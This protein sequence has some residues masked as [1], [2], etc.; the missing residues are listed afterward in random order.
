MKGCFILPSLVA[1]GAE[2]V[3]LTLYEGMKKNHPDTILIIINN[4]GQLKNR[5][6][7]DSNIYIIGRKRLLSSLP[8]LCSLIRKLNPDFIFSSLWHYNVA[9]TAFSCLFRNSKIVVREAN[10]PNKSINSHSYRWLYKALYRYLYPKADRIIASSF[11][12][13]LEIEKYCNYTGENISVLPNPVDEENIRDRARAISRGV[14]QFKYFVSVGRLTYQKG[15]DRLIKLLFEAKDCYLVIIGD[16][17]DKGKLQHLINSYGIEDRVQLVGEKENPWTWIAGADALLMAS[18]W[19]GLPN[20]VL[21]S[22]ACGTK[23]IA[24]PESGAIREI[25]DSLIKSEAIRLARF[26]KEYLTEISNVII[27]KS[28]KLEE[29]YMPEKYKKECVISAFRKII[30]ELTTL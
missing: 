1:G 5:I 7:Y 28:I 13:K 26:D 19:E 22:L 16:G 24:T 8:K 12:M 17:K 10:Y 30:L 23:V 11:E 27:R 15:F 14:P 4:K 2:N 18:R 25:K 21:E 3:T 29:S 6:K 20:V 9:I